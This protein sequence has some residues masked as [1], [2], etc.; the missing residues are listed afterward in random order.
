VNG[1]S[2]LIYRKEERKT[3]DVS[4]KDEKELEWYEVSIYAEGA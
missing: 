4:K 2:N 3:I 1:M